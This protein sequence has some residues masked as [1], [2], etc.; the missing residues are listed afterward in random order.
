MAVAALVTMLTFGALQ[1]SLFDTR[2]PEDPSQTGLDF[3]PPTDPS[4]VIANL[5]GAIDQKNLANYVNCFADP[6]K[7]NIPFQFVASGDALAQYPTI[8]DRW[9]LDDE[10]DYFQNM[11]ARTPKSAFTSLSLSLRSSSIATDSVTLNYDYVLTVEHTDAGVPR[12]ARGNMQFTLG[13]D[14][15]NFWMIYRWMDF[16]TTSDVT[17]STFKGHFSN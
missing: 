3:Q 5:Q 13:M 12:T 4:L 6:T 2:D 9:T 15:T 16:K 11:M 8:L 10:H 17:W 14:R 1:C 7:T